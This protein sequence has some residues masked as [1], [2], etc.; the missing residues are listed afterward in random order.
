M[1]IVLAF[2][3]VMALEVVNTAIEGLVDLASPGLHPLAKRAK[4]AGAGA[5]LL[6]AAAA[7]ALGLLVFLPEI[8][9]FGQDFMV[10]WRESALTM[11]ATGVLMGL[12]YGALWGWIDRQARTRKKRR[13]EP[14]R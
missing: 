2:G 4:D 9:N 14:I 13:P 11:A 5:V 7:F 10:R 3:L 1:G 6:A 12:S 8:G